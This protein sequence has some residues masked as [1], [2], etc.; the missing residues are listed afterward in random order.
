MVNMIC[1]KK[2]T[3]SEGENDVSVPNSDTVVFPRPY[4]SVC[5]F[6]PPQIKNNIFKILLLQHYL[7]ST[8]AL[9]N[10]R[11][12]ETRSIVMRSSHKFIKGLRANLRRRSRR[13]R[14]P[15]AYLNSAS[16]QWQMRDLTK[17]DSATLEQHSGRS[18]S[19]S[20]RSPGPMARVLSDSGLRFL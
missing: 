6:I 5:G 9:V 18:Q 17:S 13:V 16:V 7:W 15:V 14:N 3:L 1:L 8:G 11:I 12:Y 19:R 10:C 20:Y 4:G 2:K